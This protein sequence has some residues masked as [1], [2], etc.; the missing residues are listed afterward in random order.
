VSQ[1]DYRLG[2]GDPVFDCLDSPRV[3]GNDKEEGRG[4][5][6][7]PCHPRI[8]GGLVLPLSSSGVD[9]GIQSLAVWIPAFAGMT[10][11][12]AGMTKEK[13]KGAGMTK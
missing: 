12:D 13:R 7:T 1:G 4:Q 2:P 5:D 9:P 8:C 10:K 3:S 6:D 11:K